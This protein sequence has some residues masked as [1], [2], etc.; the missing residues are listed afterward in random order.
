MLD[1]RPQRLPRD[2]TAIE[3]DGSTLSL[4]GQVY[5][6]GFIISAWPAFC[7]TWLY[8]FAAY[9]AV[10]VALGW[11]PALVVSCAAGAVWP[12]LVAATVVLLTQVI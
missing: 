9:G 2:L 1:S 7:L 6:V 10:G 4:F 3:R 8:C 5:T 12:G 11:L